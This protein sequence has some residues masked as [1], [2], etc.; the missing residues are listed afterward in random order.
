MRQR[1]V[2]L[3]A[4]GG[5]R[6]HK[7]SVGHLYVL[8]STVVNSVDVVVSVHHLFRITVLVAFYGVCFRCFPLQ[9]EDTVCT[10]FKFSYCIFVN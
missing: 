10:L 8:T 4:V 9:L 6:L 7:G 5:K 2:F 3:N 1:Q